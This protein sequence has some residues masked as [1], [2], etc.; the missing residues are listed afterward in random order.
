MEI[1]S[2]HTPTLI[3][4]NPSGNV[5]FSDYRFIQVMGEFGSKILYGL[6]LRNIL[7]MDSDSISRLAEVSQ[8]KPLFENISISH[9]TLSGDTVESN[10]TLIAVTGEN[11][12]FLGTDV[13]LYPLS[14]PNP[15]AADITKIM[16]HSDVIRTYVEMELNSPNSPHP[17]T[18]TQSYLVVQFNMLQ[19]MLA[20]LGGP[21]MRLTFE[22]IVNSTA[23]Y[24]GLPILMERGYL[25]FSRKDVD[26]NG[27]RSLLQTASDYAV[28]VIGRN[29]VKREMLLA[30][31][32]VG[33][34]TLE[35][36]TK[37]GLRIFSSD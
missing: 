30:D 1:Q 26:I 25:G 13:V 5:I 11:G 7:I 8:Q 2:G 34:K 12:N 4:T 20:R 15:A 24:M 21:D 9:R 22:K 19:I 17:R 28:T 16:T 18:F 6:P 36:I 3:F 35:L 37:M 32:Y 14:Q 33:E 27:Y 10:A 29:T 23:R 31:K